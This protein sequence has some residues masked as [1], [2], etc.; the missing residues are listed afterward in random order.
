MNKAP[1]I[2]I[3]K[4]LLIRKPI[5]SDI[6]DR[7]SYGRPKEFR[8]MVGGSMKDIP[9]YTYQDAVDFYERALSNEFNWIIEYKSK[10][11]GICRLTLNPER[12][13]ARYSIGIYDESL[14]SKGIGTK[15]T[16]SVVEYAFNS[17]HIQFIQLMVLEFNKRAIRAYEKVGFTTKKVL[18]NNA[19]IDGVDYNDI[20]MEINR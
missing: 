8:K 5:K 20:I 1:A 14:Y 16:N 10:L 4:D 2:V 6:D 9:G 11:I 15:V 7:L 18:H 12:D 17:L 3:N 19:Q 13:K